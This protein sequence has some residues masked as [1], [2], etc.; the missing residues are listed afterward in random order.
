MRQIHKSRSEIKHRELSSITYSCIH[1]PILKYVCCLLSQDRGY[2]EWWCPRTTRGGRNL[3]KRP[4]GHARI[5]W[6]WKSYE[7]HSGWRG[8]DT[9]RY[10]EIHKSAKLILKPSSMALRLHKWGFK[11]FSAQQPKFLLIDRWMLIH[12]ATKQFVLKMIFLID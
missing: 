5:L 2:G 11:G 6:K 12:I 10:L 7:G 3:H 1:V 8:L 9:Y 4:S